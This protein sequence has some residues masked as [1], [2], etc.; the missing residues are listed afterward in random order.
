MGRKLLG[1]IHLRSGMTEC[2]RADWPL[3]GASMPTAVWQDWWAQWHCGREDVG[4]R[5]AYGCAARAPDCDGW[6]PG[7]A[8]AR[9]LRPARGFLARLPG[10]LRRGAQRA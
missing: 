6:L 4:A 8:D 2:G 7:G 5:W 3:Q 10:A 1:C 9:H